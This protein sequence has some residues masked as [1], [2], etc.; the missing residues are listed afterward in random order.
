MIG[1]SESVESCRS[2]CQDVGF[3]EINE[4]FSAVA[5]ANNSKL[6]LDESI[7]NV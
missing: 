3:Y 2:K 4:A 5:L 7:V 6:G 1:H